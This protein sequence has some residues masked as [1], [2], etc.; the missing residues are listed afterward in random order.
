[1]MT[2]YC[3][4]VDGRIS[5]NSVA[6]QLD[7]LELDTTVASGSVAVPDDLIPEGATDVYGH[8]SFKKQT[9]NLPV[10][11]KRETVSV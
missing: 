8:Y 7:G 4:Q 5:P 2:L 1:M 11:E 6:G 9:Q 10:F 3:L